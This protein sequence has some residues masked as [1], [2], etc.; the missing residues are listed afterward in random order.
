MPGHS[1]IGMVAVSFLTETAGVSLRGDEVPGE[2]E[3]NQS[4][5]LFLGNSDDDDP[6]YART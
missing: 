4:Q 5:V 2:A 6:E 3:D 1:L